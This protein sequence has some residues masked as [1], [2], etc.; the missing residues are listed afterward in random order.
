MLEES[1]FVRT[2]WGKKTGRKLNIISNDTTDLV[3]MDKK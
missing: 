2:H 1:D 3:N